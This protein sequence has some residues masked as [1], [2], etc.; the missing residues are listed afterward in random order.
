[1]YEEISGAFTCGSL[2]YDCTVRVRGPSNK[3]N[4]RRGLGEYDF[5]AASL[6]GVD[7]L[8]REIT[9]MY[10]KKTDKQR[11]VGVFYWL[12]VGNNEF[13]DGVYDNTKLMSTPEGR[14]ALFATANPPGDG[15]PNASPLHYMHWTN[16]PMFG[17]Y[18]M[19]DPWIIARHIEMLTLADIDFIFLDTTNYY[20]YAENRNQNPESTRIKASAYAVLDTWLEYYNQGWNVPKIAFYTNSCS[21]E[22]VDEIYANFYKSGKYEELWFRPNGVDPMI[23]GTTE[24]NNGASDMDVNNP[25]QYNNISASM[26]E[27]FDVKESQW[28]TKTARPNGFPWMSW[29][30]PQRYHEQSK[31]VNVSVAQHSNQAILFNLMHKWSSKGYDYH[32]DTVQENWQA[33]VNFENEWETV[34]AYE[35]AGKDVEFVTVT[36]WNEWV[37]QKSYM[38]EYTDGGRNPTGMAMVDNFDAE[39]SRDIEPD[40][41]YY[42]D[43]VYMQLVR[44]VRKLK[45]NDL[46]NANGIEWGTKTVKKISDFD[47]VQAIYKDFSGDARERDFYGFD[48]RTASKEAGLAGAWYTDKTARN[49]ITEVRTVHDKSNLYMLVTT[50]ENITP[51]EGG[52]N[53]MNVLIKTNASTAQDSF[54][55]YDYILNRNPSDGTTSIERST[56]GYQW[57]ET[58]KATYV[59][60]G[61]KMMFTVPLSALGLTADSVEFAFKVA[62]NVQKPSWYDESDPEYDIMYHYITGDS[63][64]I[65]RLHYS[66][67]YGRKKA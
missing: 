8:G 28:P 33:G 54:E 9:P 58:G 26:Q 29:E 7:R 31:T 44:N 57:T 22:R 38:P 25:T 47:D 62:D 36:G 53:W 65:G 66:Y 10:A 40:R 19:S 15:Q 52:D 49:D 46:Q 11:F 43:N 41:N 4:P 67:G 16:E 12:W 14:E 59:V 3:G 55:G 63:A 5:T 13:Q 60:E 50:A 17:Y 27:Y 61:N 35:E 64:P 21:G 1:M 45:Y 51:Y 23:I 42:K 34:F 2:L 30:Y 20:T 56:G 18:N 39:Y 48:V 24:N 32:T 6:A 37:V